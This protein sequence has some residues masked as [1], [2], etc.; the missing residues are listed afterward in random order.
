MNLFLQW[1]PLPS[2]PSCTWERPLLPR[3]SISRIFLLLTLSLFLFPFLLPVHGSDAELDAANRAYTYG[4]YDESA[5]LFQQIVATRGYSAPLCFDLANAE[6]RAG[7]MGAALLNYERAR[8]L[9]PGDA[10]IEHNLQLA[11]KQAGLEPNSYRWWEVALRSINWTVWLG[12]LAVCV[13]LIFLAVI[14]T[15]YT[16]AIS[17]ASKLSTG[18]LKNIFRGILFGGLPLCLLMGYVELSTIGLNNRIEGVIVAP[19]AAILR[20][21]PFESAD[22]IGSIPEGEL[23]TV[24]DRHKDYLRI[25]ARNHHFGWVREKDLEPVIAGSFDGNP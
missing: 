5:K 18:L 8:Y 11:R 2:F 4:S 13:T 21:S 23:V 10:G 9:A 24:E 6:A 25:E 19:K 7:H 14:G 20:L 1:I 16:P 12:T 22:S 15:A 3:N 17:S